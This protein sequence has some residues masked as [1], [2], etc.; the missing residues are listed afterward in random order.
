MD[1]ERRRR[2]AI[3]AL[4]IAGGGT[5]PA[6][7]AGDAREACRNDNARGLARAVV[8]ARYEANTLVFRLSSLMVQDMVYT[9][10]DL[11]QGKT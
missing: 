9:Q 2:Q 5:V 4:F 11:V 10:S 3:L 1:H 6:A 8:R 7:G